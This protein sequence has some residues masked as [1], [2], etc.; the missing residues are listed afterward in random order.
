MGP[1]GSWTAAAKG[2]PKLDFFSQAWI[3]ARYFVRWKYFA[4]GEHV[5]SLE[6]DLK[7][8]FTTMPA[9]LILKSNFTSK[10]E[11]SG[12]VIKININI[13]LINQNHKSLL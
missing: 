9:T 11:V 12:Q 13:N 5:L 3:G 1:S 7:E 4:I 2:V 10:F 6:K 8:N